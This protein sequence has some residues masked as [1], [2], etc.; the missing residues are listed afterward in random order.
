M[1]RTLSLRDFSIGVALLGIWLFFAF[2]P[3]TAGVFLTPRNLSN[4]SIEFAIRA[5]LAL[6]MLV[7]LLPGMIDLSAG[8][9]VGMIGGIA[10]VLVFHHGWNAG[11][12]MAVGF[13]V[14][15]VVWSA[16]GWLISSQRMP[17]FIITLG[18]MMGFQGIFWW[19]IQCKTVPVV[20]GD[21]DNL[22]SI[23]TTY[24]LPNGV[25]LA[26]WAA[27]SVAVVWGI[28]SQRR[29]RQA[30]GF[31]VEPWQISYLKGLIFIQIA[32]LF[33][34]TMNRF[35]GIPLAMVVLGVVAL[36]I[37]TLT[38][39]T[40]FGRYLYAI[41]GNEEA[42]VLSGISVLK[43]TTGA[44]LV[45][46]IVVALA[47]FMQ[48]A[49]AGAATTTVGEAMELDAIAA[50]VIG[51]TSLT[52]GRGNVLGV[53][54]GSLIMVSLLNG[55]VLMTLPQEGRLVARGVVLVLAVWMDLYLSRRRA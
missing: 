47:G 27:V 18:G 41:G 15:I 23:L 48:T 38:R 45:Q 3:R 7:V 43:V 11:A 42:A 51:G 5:S 32:L 22:I 33:T 30:Y 54:A 14:A 31:E 35:R 19:I 26:L 36:A 6:G 37:Y 9:G 24:S 46:G 29:R 25:G 17:P 40:P 13:L 10:A 21:R 8:S 34:V 50:C 20:A 39:H 1:K 4:L 16:M 2:H 49:Y 44:F 28:A 53:L 52:G 12:A 55:M